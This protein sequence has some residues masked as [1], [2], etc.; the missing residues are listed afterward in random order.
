MS[1]PD[2][3]Q[4][5]AFEEAQKNRKGATELLFVTIDSYASDTPMMAYAIE[6][7]T[8]RKFIGFCGLAP[9]EEGEVEIMYA[10]MPNFRGNGYATETASSLAQYAV[11]QLGYRRVIA[12]IA[13]N[14]VVSKAV[15]AKAGFDDHGCRTNLQ[16]S[17][18]IHF[19]VYEKKES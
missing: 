12:P 1:D 5:L 18:K 15:A 7:Y 9:R 3:T 17:E 16:S 6:E 11:N 19:Y 10:I 8:S 4:F 13:P 14:H 2:S